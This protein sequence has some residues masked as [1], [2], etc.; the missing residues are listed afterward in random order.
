MMNFSIS[1]AS[2]MDIPA[3]IRAAESDP[4]ALEQLYQSAKQSGQAEVFRSAISTCCVEAPDNLL[5]EA[6]KVRLES[7]EKE[8][9]KA[10]RT[11]NWAAAVPLSILTG[12]I[13]WA[14]SD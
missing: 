9:A 12:L 13:F 7:T 1:S 3:G 8:P 11:I 5:Y 14:L 10:Q 2:N 6:W 4:R